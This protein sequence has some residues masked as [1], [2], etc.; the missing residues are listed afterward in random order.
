M[1]S[2]SLE[3]FNEFWNLPEPVING[4]CQLSTPG[5][6]NIHSSVGEC[7]RLRTR[8]W[9][10]SHTHTTVFWLLSF[11]NEFRYIRLVFTPNLCHCHSPSKFTG[12]E[13]VKPIHYLCM[14][15]MWYLFT[16][17]I[18]TVDP[19]SICVLH[20]RTLFIFIPFPI[21]WDGYYKKK[22]DKEMCVAINFIFLYL[23][24]NSNLAKIENPRKWSPKRTK[25]SVELC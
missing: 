20:K 25:N 6:L 1:L 5:H 9:K 15:H 2:V 7:V 19:I 12:S 17:L 8:T 10:P 16:L 4:K 22:C 18:V 13:I 3:C 24:F 21:P 14:W 11:R 23:Y